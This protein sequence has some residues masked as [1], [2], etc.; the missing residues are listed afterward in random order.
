MKSSKRQWCA[1]SLCRMS[2]SL[3]CHPCPPLLCSHGV[4]GI[5]AWVFLR[6]FPAVFWA[7]V[8]SCCITKKTWPVKEKGTWITLVRISKPKAC[9]CYSKIHPKYCWM[10]GLPPRPGEDLAHAKYQI[11]KAWWWA[12]EP[13]FLCLHYSAVTQGLQLPKGWKILGTQLSLS[14]GGIWALEI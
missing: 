4:T 13:M 10:S 5:R 7:L 14:F 11:S 8:R 9:K 3:H 2:P 6:W 1:P 12:K